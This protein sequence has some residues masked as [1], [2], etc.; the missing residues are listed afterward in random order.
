MSK[1]QGFVL[2][3]IAIVIAVGG[4]FSPAVTRVVQSLGSSAGATFG[5]AKYAGV[6]IA[7]TNQGANGTS[8]SIINTDTSVRYVTGLRLA[9]TGLGNSFSSGVGAGL[10]S[11][12]VTV[13]T[14]STAAPV[15]Q[16]SVGIFSRVSSGLII[17]TATP[18]F[19]IA[20]S[21]TQ[22]ATSTLASPWYPNEYMT[23]WWNATSTATSTCTEGVDYIGG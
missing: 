19:V 17:A 4:Y 18:T 9:C 6:V 3:A 16:A 13:G 2:F 10:A 22:I 15:A 5:D 7:L 23:F 12:Q 8:T 21:T 1:L 20:S 14:S 11:L